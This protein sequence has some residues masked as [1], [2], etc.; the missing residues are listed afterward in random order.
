MIS[1]VVPA[2][3][4]AGN[5]PAIFQRLPKMG[6]GTELIFVEGHSRDTTFEAIEQSMREN[7]Q[8]K[9]LLLKQSGIGKADAVRLGGIIKNALENGDGPGVLDNAEQFRF[10]SGWRAAV[11]RRR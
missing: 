3:N 10:Y 6:S 8:R 7:P 1:V 9:S 5:I 2:R 4:E 11:E